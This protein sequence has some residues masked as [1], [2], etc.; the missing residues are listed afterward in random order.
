MMSK[1]DIAAPSGD[2]IGTVILDL[3]GNVPMTAA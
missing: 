2:S 1:R 3:R